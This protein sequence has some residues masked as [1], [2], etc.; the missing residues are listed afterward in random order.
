M[1]L[2][3]GLLEDSSAARLLRC[4]L[5]GWFGWGQRLAAGRPDHWGGAGNQSEDKARYA[6]LHLRSDDTA[7]RKCWDPTWSTTVSWR[8]VPFRNHL[9][10]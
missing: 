9:E 6:Y 5:W 4:P 2:G 7:L 3:A 8:T 1:T 10:H